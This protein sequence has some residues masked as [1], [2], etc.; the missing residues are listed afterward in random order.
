MNILRN[1]VWSPEFW[2][3]PVWQLSA[4]IGHAGQFSSLLSRAFE[5][6]DNIQRQGPWDVF[7]NCN[8]QSRDCFNLFHML[9]VG[10]A[11]PDSNSDHPSAFQAL[12]KNCRLPVIQC[13]K[14]SH[15]Q[16][17]SVRFG[18]QQP[19]KG[20]VARFPPAHCVAGGYTMMGSRWFQKPAKMRAPWPH[21]A[22][23][24]KSSDPWEG[25][26]KKSPTIW[27]SWCLRTPDC[28]VAPPMKLSLH[29]SNSVT[30]PW[31]RGLAAW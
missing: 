25:S 29:Q 26:C 28:C 15:A 23:R 18:A 21:G 2:D 4:V 30:Q 12:L 16:L 3:K 27:K 8:P 24:K 20:S 1:Q 6:T 14:I 17:P 7:R 13:L 5:A 19:A 31:R 11:V 22:P 10:I 9:D